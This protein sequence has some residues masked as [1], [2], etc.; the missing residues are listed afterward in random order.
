MEFQIDCHLVYQV[1]ESA[2]FLFNV[3]AV[4]NSLQRV[5]NEDLSMTGAQP[6]EE[7]AASGQRLHRIAAGTGRVE[8]TY[9]AVISVESEL[10]DASKLDVAPL[11]KLP[12]EALVFLYPSRFCQSDLLA[13]FANREF[14]NFESGFE[15]LTRICNWIYEYVEYLQGSTNSS[16]SAFDTATQRAGVCRDFA[17]LGIALCRALGIPARFVSGYAYGLNPPDFHAYFEAF[18]G[19]RWI[20]AD[21]TRLSPQS[22]FIRIGEGRDAADTSFATIFGN[23]TLTEMHLSMRLATAESQVP[24]YVDGAISNCPL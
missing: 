17:H 4:H 1:V 23:A 14:T 3:A 22:S 20:I 6:A 15:R 2:S 16:T 12:R 21:P 11:H 9:H 24:Q 8:L 13:R 19:G 18:L 7:L 10:L 5:I